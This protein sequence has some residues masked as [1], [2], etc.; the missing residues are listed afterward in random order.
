MSLF[1]II[2]IYGKINI[3]RVRVKSMLFKQLVYCYHNIFWVGC[4]FFIIYTSHINDFQT[5]L[6]D[7]SNIFYGSS[8]T[9]YLI[10]HDSSCILRRS[11]QS[12]R[13]PSSRRCSRTTQLL[14]KKQPDGE[15]LT[16]LCTITPGRH[17]PADHPLW[18]NSSQSVTASFL[19]FYLFITAK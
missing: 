2:A 8:V 15:P 18:S 6:E 16:T 5:R 11:V 19:L 9:L 17:L 13:D 3:I 10:L 1:F 7:L 12:S 14:L 4:V